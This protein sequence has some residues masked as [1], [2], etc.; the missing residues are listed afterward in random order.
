MEYPR[1]GLWS[2]AFVTGSVGGDM[3]SKLSEEMVS[4]FIPTTPNPTSGWYAIVP[5][6]EVIN[7]TISVEDAFKIIVS[8]GIVNTTSSS[9]VKALNPKTEPPL[10]SLLKTENRIPA[11]V[12]EDEGIGVSEN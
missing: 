7:L 5:Q 12:L 10:E 6:Q 1:R 2:L 4:V 11:I 3:Q 8:G 9:T